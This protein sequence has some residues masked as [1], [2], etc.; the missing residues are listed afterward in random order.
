MQKIFNEICEKGRLVG[1]SCVITR[2]GAIK[3]A[4]SYGMSS[5]EDN[6]L[7]TPYTIYRIASISKTVMALSLMKL[8]EEGRLSIED[9]ISTI[10]GFLVRNPRFPE[11]SITIK[12]LL[13]Q[14]SSITDGLD[15]ESTGYNHV[16]GT[17]RD[18][19]LFDLLSQTGSCFVP[20]TF[21]KHEPGTKF[22]YANFNC[23]ILSCI[24]EKVSGELFTEYVKKVVFFPLGLDASYRPSDIVNSD[25]ASLYYADAE[26]VRLSRTREDFLRREYKI[27]PLG[28]NYRGPAGG[29]FINMIDLC[30]IASVF[31]NHGHPILKKETIDLMLQKHWEGPR[32]GS[33]QA[34]G[35]QMIILDDFKVRLYGHF[36]DAYGAKS[37]MLFNPEKEIA[38]TFITNGGHYR[39]QDNGICDVH[40]QMIHAFLEHYGA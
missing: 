34:K 10:L 19:T 9:D 28:E 23:G 16:N 15:D 7:V 3:E 37:F 12:M 29:L 8:V 30:R 32:N 1:A 4:L 35:L 21:D 14:T 18:V 2:H 20:E 40:E 27:F 24:I 38:I 31:I 33:Y 17:N 36:G 39:S 26:E 6:R 25:I 5:L 11:T 13:T 22:L